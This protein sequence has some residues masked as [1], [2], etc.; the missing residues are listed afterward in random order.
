MQQLGWAANMTRIVPL[1]SG[2]RKK[3]ENQQNR[4]EML[5]SM[6]YEEVFIK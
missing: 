2:Q 3:V 6:A 4:R 5:V 1:A